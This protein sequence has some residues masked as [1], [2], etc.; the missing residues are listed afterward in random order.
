MGVGVAFAVASAGSAA[1]YQPTP[2]NMYVAGNPAACNKNPCV[3]Y[4]KSAQLPSG[5]I[6]ATFENS[7]TDPVGQTLPVYKSDDD[8]TTWQKLADVKPPAAL[9][10]DPQYAKYTSNWTNAYPYTLPQDV[11]DLK[12][13]TLLLASIVSGDDS[14]YREQKAADPTWTQIGRAHV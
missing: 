13:G 5:R 10:S 4:P 7:Q 12:A 3:L 1:A 8:G 2:S 6:V 11:G 9:S 14:Y